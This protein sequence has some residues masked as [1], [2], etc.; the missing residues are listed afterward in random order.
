MGGPLSGNGWDEYRKL[1][2]AHMKNT[3]ESL[4]RIE[5]RQGDMATEMARTSLMTK[6][7][8]VAIAAV[9]SGAVNYFWPHK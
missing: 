4:L 9:V 2:E 6:I 7:F 3:E 1:V 8:G 5:T